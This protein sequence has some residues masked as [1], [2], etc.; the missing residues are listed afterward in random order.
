MS[1]K[2]QQGFFWHVHHEELIEW[3][4]SYDERVGF[5]L[6]EKEKDEQELRLRL[7]KPVKGNLPQEVIKA[8]QAYDK[9]IQDYDACRV[10]RVALDEAWQAYKKALSKNMPAIEALHAVECP[11]CP[12]DGH[13]IFPNT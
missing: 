10:Q 8:W 4:F 1:T 2:K 3:C 9:A 13:T 6:N 11:N 7:L 12:W 5:I